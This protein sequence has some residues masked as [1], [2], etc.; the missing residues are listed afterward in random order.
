MKVIEKY[1]TMNKREQV[2]D[3]EKF[4][5]ENGIGVTPRQLVDYLNSEAEEDPL[6]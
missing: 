4:I 5:N 3:C 1:L 6:S 2:K